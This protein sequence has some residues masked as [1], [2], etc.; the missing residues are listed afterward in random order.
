MGAAKD[1]PTRKVDLNAFVRDVEAGLDDGALMAGHGITF[2]ELKRLLRELVRTGL[3]TQSYVDDRSWLLNR[4][5]TKGEVSPT[6]SER[7]PA[8]NWPSTDG[9]GRRLRPVEDR[10][11][12]GPKTAMGRRHALVTAY[13]VASA[14]LILGVCHMMDTDMWVGNPDDLVPPPSVVS[15]WQAGPQSVMM[16]NPSLESL[17]LELQMSRGEELLDG[18][19]KGRIQY[20]E[21]E[22]FS[23]HPDYDRCR[24][25]IEECEQAAPGRDQED[26]RRDCL[27]DCSAAARMLLNR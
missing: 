13:L 14:L 25:C 19:I 8:G 12:G 26:C 10:S 4:A 24:P 6:S 23:F 16:N 7:V 18:L 2:P 27:S 22:Q 9:P 1:E 3:L 17:P 15:G 21:L 5:G 11:G 20:S